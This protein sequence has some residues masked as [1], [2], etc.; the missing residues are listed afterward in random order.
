MTDCL[1]ECNSR[2]NRP[3]VI[4]AWVTAT[5]GKYHDDIRL[6][7]DTARESKHGAVR[8]SFRT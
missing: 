2:A 4:Q 1:R 5:N 3:A 7:R 8:I 6:M